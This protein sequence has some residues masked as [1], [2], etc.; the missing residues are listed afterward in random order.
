[1]KYKELGGGENEPGGNTNLKIRQFDN[2]RM[3][4]KETGGEYKF[5]NSAI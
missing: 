5:D 3:K 4:Y 1:M 2:L